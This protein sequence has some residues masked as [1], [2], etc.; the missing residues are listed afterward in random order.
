M[1]DIP[2]KIRE[3]ILL[4]F[5]NNDFSLENDLDI[6]NEVACNILSAAQNI[7]SWSISLNKLGSRT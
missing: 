7:C 1:F 5:N 2:L 4:L 6:S 3:I